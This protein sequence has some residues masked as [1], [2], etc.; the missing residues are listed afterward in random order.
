MG[1]MTRCDYDP[2]TWHIIVDPENV[3]GEQRIPCAEAHGLDVEE[4]DDA[5]EWFDT[6]SNLAAGARLR[7]GVAS[8]T[9]RRGNRSHD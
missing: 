6:P 4:L 2:P 7:C 9:T 3:E 1:A 8:A 5:E